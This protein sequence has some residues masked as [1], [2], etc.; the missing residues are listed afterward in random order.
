MTVRVGY[1]SIC[2]GGVVGDPVGVTS[3]KDL[4]YLSNGDIEKALFDI[5]ASGYQGF[6]VFDGNLAAYSDDLSR[7]RD[8]ISDTGLTPVGVYSGANFVFDEILGEELSRI[9]K[10]AG[11]AA[12]IGASY[13][14]IGG[15]AQRSTGIEDSDYT[16]LGRALD[17]VVA[18]ARSYGLDCVFHPHLTTIVESP[19]Q[20]ARVLSE[21]EIGLCVDTA[22]VAAGGGDPVEVIRTH[23][24]RLGYVHLKDLIPEPFSFQPLG[25]GELDLAGVVEALKD[26][27]YD[28]WLTVELDSYDGDPR[29][30]ADT[31][32]RFLAD[33]GI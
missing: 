24:D 27:D 8:V 2:W 6:E 25:R 13:L 16:K 26:V 9:E 29:E 32:R 18:I 17:R 22:H 12:E 3:I 23:A 19:K 28:G 33:L 7:I 1:H 14:V 30:A 10:S 20:I 11:L 21:S 4:F 31:S 5:A 15:G